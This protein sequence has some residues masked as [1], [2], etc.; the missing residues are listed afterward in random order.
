MT[1]QPGS[2]FLAVRHLSIVLFA[3]LWSGCTV[4]SYVAT[5]TTGRNASGVFTATT[6]A[7][8]VMVVEETSSVMSCIRRVLYFDARGGLH[9]R[10]HV[11]EAHAEDSDCDMRID[12]VRL[13]RV[14]DRR[15]WARN[16]GYISSDL[17]KAYYRALT[18]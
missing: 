8:R 18:Q 9:S 2:R 17:E 3:V 6:S 4:W 12:D 10:P 7:Y 5:D 13:T 16:R 14:S 11:E 1:M 15:A